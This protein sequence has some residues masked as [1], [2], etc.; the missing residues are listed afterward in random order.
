I[1][2]MNIGLI[3]PNKDRRYKT[4]HLGL[5]YLV[6][7]ARQRF[8]DLSF[9]V[10]DTRVAT[11]QETKRFFCSSFD[12]I[13]I[14]VF[15]P[16]YYE[17]IDVLHRVR[18]SFDGTPVCLGGP[19]VTT[20]MEDIFKKTPADFAVYGEGE[21]T[22]SDLIS[23][24]K[25]NMDIEGIAGL[26]FKDRKGKIITNPPRAFIKDL[27]SVPFPAWDIF[28][29]ERYPLHRMVSSRGCPYQCSWCNSSSVWFRSYRTREPENMLQ[30]IECLLKNYG[31][32]IFIFGDNSFNIDLKR[33]ERFC[34]LLLNRNIKILWSVSLRADLMTQELAFLMKEAGCYNVAIGIES[35]N[36]EILAKMNKSTTIGKITEGIKMLKNA[37]I[38][39]MSQYVIGSPYETLDTVKESVEYAKKSGCDYTNFYTVLPFKGT[40]QWDYVEN[41]G[42]FYTREIHDFHTIEPRIVFETPEFP[43]KD[44]LEAIKLVKRNGFYSNK[45]K[46]SWWFDMAKESSEKIQKM[47]PEAAGENLYMLLK[48]IYKMKLVKKNNV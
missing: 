20:I 12:L 14:T 39:V 38:E 48:S 19:Y 5:A 21:V 25:G 42:T 44:R 3:F 26:M 6:A 7:Y 47:L 32:K 9:K 1:W 23:H 40:P 24:L 22:F 18:K 10:L 46:K 8:D 31:K 37:G 13:G 45:D 11:R 2:N 28:P 36:N 17:V 30:E 41:H 34:E 29:M 27:N 33:V 15:S 43:Y 4:I 16:V 35:A